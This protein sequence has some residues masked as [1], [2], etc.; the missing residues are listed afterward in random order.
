MAGGGS[1]EK[2]RVL[3][4]E[5]KGAWKEYNQILI[6]IEEILARPKAAQ[7]IR[8]FMKEELPQMLDVVIKRD[9]R[10]EK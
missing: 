1:K 8:R 4:I 9:G 2:P 5:D 3:T 10:I 7:N 6:K